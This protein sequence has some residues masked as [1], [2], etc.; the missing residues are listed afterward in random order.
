METE[1]SLTASLEVLKGKER[2]EKGG[3]GRKE[4]LQILSLPLVVSSFFFSSPLLL[5]FFF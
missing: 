5:F 4:D 1:G 3:Y 2:D